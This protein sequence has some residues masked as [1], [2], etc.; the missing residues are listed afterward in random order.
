M[1]G[2]KEERR[3]GGKGRKD[4]R[5]VGRNKKGGTKERRSV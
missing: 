3:G 1:E 5:R 4:G 2:S